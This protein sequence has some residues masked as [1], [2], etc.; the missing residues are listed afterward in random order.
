MKKNLFILSAVCVLFATSVSAQVAADVTIK[1][2]WN[3]DVDGK[4]DDAIWSLIDPVAIERNF[5]AEEPSVTAFFKMYYTDEYLYLLVD[6]QDD[7]HYPLWQN[8]EDSKR[9]YL[10]DKVELYF[11][12]ND[13]LKDGKG[14]SHN[15][16]NV[17]PIAPGHAQLAPA[18]EEG[19]YDNPFIPSNAVYNYL[20]NQVFVAYSTKADNTSYTIE[21][22]FPL[23]AFINDRGENL[24]EAAFKALPNGMGFDVTVVDND[25]DG[26]SR[27]RKVW[28]SQ[29]NEAYVNMDDCG[30]IVFGDEVL[31][32]INSPAISNAKLYPNPVKSELTIE[33][34][35]DQVVFTNMAGQQVKMAESNR[36]VN[37]SELANGLYIVKTYQNGV[38]T[39]V[40][41]MTKE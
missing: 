6:V 5:Q 40:A 3:I 4:P 22:E 24:S 19:N 33:G 27:K 18:F 37:V 11:D 38:W 21:Y 1:K 8:P 28:R 15:G 32:G 39:G 41:K 23:D 20:N 29:T 17:P 13:V 7:V 16:A 31:S 2:G 10:Y 34:D 35:F 14:P 9:E 25:N 12:I 36:K 30:V 26:K